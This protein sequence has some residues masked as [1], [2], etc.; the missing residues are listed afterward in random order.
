MRVC[1]V[2]AGPSGLTTIKQLRDD[3]H[4]VICFEKDSDVGGIWRRHIDDAKD[5]KVFDSLMLTVSMKLMAFSDFMHEGDRTFTD[6]RGYLEYLRAYVDRFSLRDYVQVNTKV[7]GTHYEDGLW[8]I[9]TQGPA[10]AHEHEF[11]ALAICTGPFN[12]P[13]DK[14]A[15]LEGFTGEVQHSA[16]YR[17]GESFRGKRV[18]V[19]GLAESGADVVRELAEVAS[20]CALAVRSRTFLLPRLFYGKY[21]TDMMTFRAHHYDEW[22]RAAKLQPPK[23]MIWGDGAAQ[24]WLFMVLSVLYGVGVLVRQA[25]V[26]LFG[27]KAE[28]R[29]D[30]LNN[31]GEPMLPYKIDVGTENTQANIDAINAWNDKS[32]LGQGTWTQKKIF[33]KNVTFIP[34]IVSGKIKLHD[35]GIERTEGNTVYFKDGTSSDFD[36]VVLCTGFVRSIP[37]LGDIKLDNL[38]DLY[39]LAFHPSYD[40]RLA[41][42]GFVRPH[43][44]GIPVCAEMQARYFSRMCAGELELP[45]DVRERIVEERAW[46]EA[47]TCLSPRNHESVPSQILFM[48]SMARQIGCLV[49][50]RDLLFKPRLFVKHWFCSFNQACYRLVGPHSDEAAARKELLAERLPADSGRYVLLMTLLALLPS[51]IKPKNLELTLR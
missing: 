35:G 42:I 17:N 21:S 49:Q 23:G 34:H 6:H 51:F 36:A 32:H 14:I 22:V 18:L 47:L 33:C 50:T 27:K 26:A 3:G 40:G 10:G 13:N 30:T 11:D 4:D 46:Y 31:L 39:K 28:V 25:F 5:M 2:G 7:T 19:L 15:E 44:G 20:E 9:N 1:V 12:R 43:S 37:A 29:S 48:D 41:L 38:R 16:H 24:R 45:V 8:R